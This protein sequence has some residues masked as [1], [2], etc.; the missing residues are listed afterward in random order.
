MEM[1]ADELRTRTRV[2]FEPKARFPVKLYDVANDGFLVKWS[3]DGTSVFVEEDFFEERV[4]KCYPGFVQI[5]S[6]PNVRRLFREYSFDWKVVEGTKSVFEFSH[7][8]F[9]RN[10]EE[11]L[12]GI[13]TKRKSFSRSYS[14]KQRRGLQP[15]ATSSPKRRGLRRPYRR[16][17]TSESDS[18]PDTFSTNS[19]NVSRADSSCTLSATRSNSDF[20]Q[21]PSNCEFRSKDFEDA[22]TVSPLFSSTQVQNAIDGRNSLESD[23]RPT[24]ELDEDLLN[25]L[26]LYAQNELTEDEYLQLIADAA[27]SEQI[28][29][30]FA[31]ANA[32]DVR[33]ITILQSVSQCW[34]LPE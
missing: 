9:M 23:G 28:D 19:S 2:S 18:C 17:A 34:G 11:L 3:S 14:Y 29:N 4:M 33:E 5:A 31:R 30:H 10:R 26:A 7:P 16:R 1:L 6:F 25:V 12:L 15:L 32:D 24:H 8:D 22:V 21:T 27:A 13:K 20:S